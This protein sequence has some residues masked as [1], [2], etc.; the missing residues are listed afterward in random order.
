MKI[1]KY[2]REYKPL[3][4]FISDCLMFSH[5]VFFWKKINIANILFKLKDNSPKKPLANHDKHEFLWSQK[6]VFVHVV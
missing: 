2:T 5:D 1:Y 6:I 4:F 3:A